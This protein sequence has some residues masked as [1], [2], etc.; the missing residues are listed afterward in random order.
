MRSVVRIS[1]IFREVLA[2]D[3]ERNFTHNFMALDQ[4]EA[5]QALLNLGR[6]FQ[7][8]PVQ[9]RATITQAIDLDIDNAEILLPEGCVLGDGLRNHLRHLRKVGGGGSPE[10]DPLELLGDLRTVDV[11]SLGLTVDAD[12]LEDRL[13]DLLRDIIGRN[14]DLTLAYATWHTW[15]ARGIVPVHLVEPEPESAVSGH[16]RDRCW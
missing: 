8:E 13:L 9:T 7:L 10:V 1:A 3:G 12:S 14:A 16:A 15:P 4:L 2:S 5:L 11:V 6:R